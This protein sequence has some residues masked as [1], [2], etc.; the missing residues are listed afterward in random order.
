MPS[1]ATPAQF[2]ERVDVRSLGD[3]AADD[4][5]QVSSA[6]LLTDAN[7]QA[8]LD[9]ASGDIE[10]ALRNAGRY[11]VA[12]MAALAN[13]TNKKLVRIC[14]DLAVGYLVDRRLY[15]KTNETITRIMDRGRK[16]LTDLADGKLVLE[17]EGAI[18]AGTPSVTG[19]TSAQLDNLN[20]IARQAYRAYPQTFLPGDR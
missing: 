7:I 2:K 17:I 16:D 12:D 10:S 8:A 11:T 4:G 3:L 20:L 18:D 14:V 5:T 13:Y 6:G 15:G 1:F 19:P 9:D